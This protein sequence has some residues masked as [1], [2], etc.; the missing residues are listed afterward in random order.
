M[1][2]KRNSVKSENSNREYNTH[3]QSDYGRAKHGRA[4]SNGAI[5]EQRV[6]DSER[7]GAYNAGIAKWVNEGAA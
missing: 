6:Y 7:R 5:C 4:H 2:S 1:S 3:T